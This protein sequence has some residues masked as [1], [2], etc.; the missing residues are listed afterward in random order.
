MNKWQKILILVVLE[1]LLEF[2]GLSDISVISEFV[3]DYHIE[4]TRCVIL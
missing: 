2:S 4:V 1:T 3:F